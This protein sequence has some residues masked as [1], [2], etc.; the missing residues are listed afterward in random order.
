MSIT[1]IDGGSG[2]HNP[3]GSTRVLPDLEQQGKDDAAATARMEREEQA[4][5]D[6]HKI[7]EDMSS[8]FRQPILLYLEAKSR[9]F[10]G[11]ISEVDYLVLLRLRFFERKKTKPIGETYRDRVDRILSEFEAR[12]GDDTEAQVD[13]V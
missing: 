13:G 6:L 11:C 8:D 1:P 9:I 2:S 5:E 12:N 3:D 10:H 7:I 4:A